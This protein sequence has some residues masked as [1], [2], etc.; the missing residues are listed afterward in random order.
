MTRHAAA[1]PASR[2]LAA[3]VAAVP[4]TP[5]RVGERVECPGGL[6]QV[7]DQDAQRGGALQTQ[8]AGLGLSSTGPADTA[9][10]RLG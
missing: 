8:G 1:C 5:R 9:A 4:G 3:Q 6:V 7:A 2:S 10:S